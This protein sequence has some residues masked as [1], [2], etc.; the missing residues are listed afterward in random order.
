[1]IQLCNRSDDEEQMVVDGGAMRCSTKAEHLHHSWRLCAWVGNIGL[2][3]STD[4]AWQ[5]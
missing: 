4:G 5:F 1:M 3:R 2:Q